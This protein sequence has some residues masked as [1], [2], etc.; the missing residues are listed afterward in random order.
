MLGSQ[1]VSQGVQI[2]DMSLMPQELLATHAYLPPCNQ[3]SKVIRNATQAWH[4]QRLVSHRATHAQGESRATHTQG[5]VI[6]N[7][8]THTTITINA[9]LRHSILLISST[10]STRAIHQVLLLMAASAGAAM[11]PPPAATQ[12]QVLQQAALPTP[13]LHHGCPAQHLHMQAQPTLVESQGEIAT[14]GRTM[15]ITSI[16]AHRTPVVGA[17]I[18]LAAKWR[19]LA[20]PSPESPATLACPMALGSPL[21]Q[22]HS[23]A[24]TVITILQVC[25]CNQDMKLGTLVRTHSLTSYH[26]SLNPQLALRVDTAGGSTGPTRMCLS[27]TLTPRTPMLI[28]AHKTQEPHMEYSKAASRGALQLGIR[29]WSGLWHTLGC[30]C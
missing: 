15:V 5:E 7:T 23:Q 12:A 29:G 6:I 24:P 10:P 18:G 26:P 27:P 8:P 11:P 17:C 1:I 30:T 20:H 4:V 22:A 9:R 19:L 28:Q 3:H 21:A 2:Q 14:A 25:T 13:P 16:P